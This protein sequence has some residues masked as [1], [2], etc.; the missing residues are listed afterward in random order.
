MRTVILLQFIFLLLSCVDRRAEAEREL[1]EAE[2]ELVERLR[3]EE[4][5][6]EQAAEQA[7][8]EY[9][10]Q[11]P[12][13]VDLGDTLN[14]TDENGW[15]QGIWKYRVKRMDEFNVTPPGGTKPLQLDGKVQE[16]RQYYNDTLH[17]IFKT[18]DVF[19]N[20]RLCVKGRYVM[21]IKDGKWEY[22]CIHKDSIFD[23]VYDVDWK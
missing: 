21:G 7:Y 10:A 16:V 23:S 20:S 17:G 3:A 11:I 14:F 18:Y 4:L 15:K 2:R 12:P 8:A 13:F 22:P 19:N 6:R 1:I 9:L 5:K